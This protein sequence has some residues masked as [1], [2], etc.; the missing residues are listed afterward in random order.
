MITALYA[1]EAFTPIAKRTYL[2]TFPYTTADSIEVYEV[3]AQNIRT[4]ARPQDYSLVSN[5]DTRAPIKSSGTIKFSRPHTVGTTAVVIERNTRIDQTV[6]FPR[7][8]PFNGRMAEYVIDKITMIQQEIAERKCGA[9]G[10]TPFTQ[11]VT[12]TAYDDFK[13]AALNFA[14]EKLVTNTAAIAASAQDCR[15]PDTEPTP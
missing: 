4:L 13:A 3:D 8:R 9:S 6:D 5:G 11:L 14:V 12:W 7:S 2:F 1:P 15:D 10:S